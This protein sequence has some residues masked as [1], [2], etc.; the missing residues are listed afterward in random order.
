MSATLNNPKGPTSFDVK[1]FGF[2]AGFEV[3]Q[4]EPRAEGA[5]PVRRCWTG[6]GWLST[7]DW[8][9]AVRTGK[10][11]RGPILQARRDGTW[12]NPYMTKEQREEHR[13]L[14]LSLKP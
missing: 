2:E 6:D 3:T 12:V 1:D 11:K 10:L 4:V 8:W 9:E 7:V 14:N 13:L 5:Q